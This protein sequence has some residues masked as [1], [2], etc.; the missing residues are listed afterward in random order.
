MA[1]EGSSVKSMS[2]LPP[3]SVVGTSSIRRTAQVALK[4]PHLQVQDVRGNIP[5]RLAKLDARDGPFHGLIL[6]AA[7]LLRIDLGHRITQYLDSR[8]GGMLHAVG[9]GA[10]GVEIRE[11]DE[12]VRKLVAPINHDPALLACLTERSLLRTLEGG[13]SAPLGVET[14]WH[15]DKVTLSVR[16]TVVSPDGKESVELLQNEFVER[17]EDAERFGFDLAQQLVKRGAGKILADIQQRKRPTEVLE[18]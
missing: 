16:A 9:Q 17:S 4:Y 14:E 13:C 10:V 7:G 3:G 1:R 5:T 18:L 11:E 2:D 15:K 6:A 12:D 8:T